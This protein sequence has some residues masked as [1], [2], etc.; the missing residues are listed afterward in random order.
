MDN[1]FRECKKWGHGKKAGLSETKDYVIFSLVTHATRCEEEQ[2][3]A[4][5]VWITPG[6]A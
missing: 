2:A 5:E 3:L 6:A 1:N 4:G